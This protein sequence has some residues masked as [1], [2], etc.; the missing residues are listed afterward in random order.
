M[1]PTT[2][3]G[4]SSR[5]AALLLLAVL[6]GL[7]PCTPPRARAANIVINSTDLTINDN[8]TTQTLKGLPFRAAVE[9]G[10]A[11][12]YIAGN[13][14]FTSTDS[15]RLTGTRPVSLRVGGNVV[16][17]SGALFDA[18][19]SG[20]APGPGG[21]M[22]GDPV[23]GTAGGAGGAGGIGGAGGAGGSG[24]VAWYGNVGTGGDAGTAGGDGAKGDDGAEGLP[25]DN[26]FGSPASG[27]AG[28]LP[29]V[30][31]PAC[32]GGAG[33]AGASGGTA[34]AY[35]VFAGTDG[36]PGG[37]AAQAADGAS[38]SYGGQG[39]F[40]GSPGTNTGTG[41]ELSA[42]GGA[43]SGAGGA[44][45]GGGGGGGG[46]GGG[47]GGGAGG[48]AGAAGIGGAGGAGGHGGNGGA[49]GA[50]ADGSTSGAGGGGG[51]A[52]EI[53]ACGRLTVAGQLVARGG[54]GQIGSGHYHS[55]D[56]DE[57]S[58]GS[59]NAD[60]ASGSAGSPS[61]GIGGA[62][63]NSKSVAGGTGGNGGPGGSGGSGSGGGG[64]TVKLVA[65]AIDGAGCAVDV[66]GGLRSVMGPSIPSGGA[67]RFIVGTAVPAGFA[68][69]LTGTAA[70]TTATA[71][72][73]ANPFLVGNEKTPYI[74]SLQGG[75]DA[76]GI[77]DGFT[78]GNLYYSVILNAPAGA[79]GVVIRY[80]NGTPGF[81]DVYPGYELLVIVNITSSP[82]QYPKFMAGASPGN[83]QQ[84]L[85][86]G[87][88]RRTEFGGSGLATLAA[89]P[90]GAAYALLIPQGTRDF[91][92]SYYDRKVA[93]VTFTNLVANTPA[94]IPAP[95]NAVAR[96]ACY[97]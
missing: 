12:F 14:T 30:G 73:V 55:N 43:G 57:G 34:G 26:G 54:L 91:T 8:G 56:G 82:I 16:V 63:G 32:A 39:G 27:G 21:G 59:A 15:V 74:P 37:S 95:K 69:T 29:G 76:F 94:Y 65:T 25:G 75:P 53:F 77:M 79:R 4:F 20:V 92:F 10:I 51:G 17:E 23:G 78:V 80:P 70:I 3:F 41:E 18:S 93:S 84:L 61:C 46:N 58:A 87:Y 89:L 19:A 97:E 9:G 60:G 36:G 62:G 64:G 47:G 67:G 88:G 50:G 49:G 5:L 44:G 81:S 96:W 42:G 66:S 45:G 71:P 83:L 33:T 13:L 6:L 11:R 48:G 86:G 7:L 31:G 40:M 35:L 2:R 22:G 24:V 85:L 52:F 28:G 68:G 1:S 38:W 72:R 90:A